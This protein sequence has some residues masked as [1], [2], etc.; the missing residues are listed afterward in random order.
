MVFSVG[1]QFKEAIVPEDITITSCK[2]LNCVS[3]LSTFAY[4]TSGPSSTPVGLIKNVT[5]TN[6]FFAMGSGKAISL[7]SLANSKATN[8]LVLWP[9]FTGDS[10]TL[11]R[12]DGLEI[13][14]NTACYPSPTSVSDFLVETKESSNISLAR[15]QVKGV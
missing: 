9:T 4:G 12:D 10:L 5:L 6:N 11:F 15:N 3:P 14:D 8:N 1:D 13:S 2:F 7:S